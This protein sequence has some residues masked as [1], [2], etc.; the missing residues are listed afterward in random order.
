MLHTYKL[1]NGLNVATYELP[2]M[3]S[4]YLG[5][6]VKGG[7]IFD[8]EDK[9]GVAHFMEHLL[10]QGAPSYPDV[11]SLS[12][13]IE[14]IA[15]SYGA[16]TYS[17]LIRF[18]TTAPATHIE[19]LIKIASEVF[20]EPFFP[21]V[22]IE[23][24]RNAV[25]EEIRERQDGLGY[26]NYRFYSK[27][28][29]KPGHPL[30]ID[31]GGTEEAVRSLRRE[32]VI[33]YW[34]KFFH[35][36]NTNL[37]VVG[38]I[39]NQ[40]TK[41]LIEHYFGRYTSDKDFPGFPNV[42][43]D[44]FSD[45]AVAIRY[46]KEIKSCYIDLSFPSINDQFPREIHYVHGAIQNILGRLRRSRLYRLLRQ[47]K[48]LVYDVGITSASF[49]NFGY[50][51]IYSQVSPEN[52]EEVVRLIAQ[53]LEVFVKNGPTAEELQLAKNYSAGWSLMAF[54]HP[55][56]IGDWVEHDLIWEDKIYTPEEIV[57]MINSI[58]IEDIIEFMQKYWDFSKLNLVIQGPVPDSKAN[59]KK[60]EN[61]ISK[62]Q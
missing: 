57:D 5:V 56:G 42:T 12:D 41:K 36:K 33:E 61:L 28:R 6:S 2:E 24:E 44:D 53:E 62:L 3:R 27:V 45:R 50:T 4:V 54:D 21:E 43:N 10:V 35:P 20:F 37:I 9:A 32:D 8:N 59:I 16:V 13:F 60:Y 23:R 47:R 18:H 1:K 55:S 14:G 58:T 22:A 38:G 7:S 49:N 15:G 19:D 17:E 40:E 39:K 52:L 48:G 31:G 11:E 29:Y 30:L 25:L 46:D 34:L 51:D 26:K